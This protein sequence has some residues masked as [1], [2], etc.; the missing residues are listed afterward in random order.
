M[1]RMR[2]CFP[3]TSQYV[4]QK[5]D[6]E[7]FMGEVHHWLWRIWQVK[8]QI[9]KVK[10]EEGLWLG[11]NAKMGVVKKSLCPSLASFTFLKN[12]LF[13]SPLFSYHVLID[14]SSGRAGRKNIWFDVMTCGPSAFPWNSWDFALYT[15]VRML[16]GLPQFGDCFLL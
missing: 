9:L 6:P 2:P 10:N 13:S 14:W 5:I 4:L 16:S 7:I 1:K 12:S 15:K 11:K 3:Y 8:K